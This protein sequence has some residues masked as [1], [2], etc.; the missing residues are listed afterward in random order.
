MNILITNYEYPPIGAGGS[1]A[2]WNLAKALSR[3]GHNISVLTAAY[4]DL[5]GLSLKD[6]ISVYRCRAIR[7]KKESS[8]LFEMFTFLLSALIHLPRIKKWNIDFHLVF[9]SFPCGP[10]G[11]ACRIFFR[12]PYMVLL[13]GGDVPGAEKRLRFIHFLLN[14]MRWTVYRFSKVIVA[15]SPGLKKLAEKEDPVDVLYIPNGIDT[16]QFKPKTDY[17]INNAFRFLFVGRFQPQ[18]NLFFTLALLNDFYDAKGHPIEFHLV[19][20]GPQKDDLMEYSSK[21]SISNHIVWHSWCS[22]ENLVSHYQQADCLLNLSLYEGMP[23]TVLEAMACGLPVVASDVIGNRSLI[24]N[25]ETGFLCSL[26][27]RG[28]LLDCLTL[29]LNDEVK[30][31]MLGKESRRY[32]KERYSWEGVASQFLNLIL[33]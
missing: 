9:F 26:E 2:S 31:Q 14:P 3:K 25:S 15:N 17:S 23:N 7:K 30:R 22:R 28:Q 16:L 20:D 21:L 8:N 11:V 19:G 32:V 18:K 13:R 12:I 29:I 10:L 1:S 4:K 6:G 27:E 5:I 33:E 24:T